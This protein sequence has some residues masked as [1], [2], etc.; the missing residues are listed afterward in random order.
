MIQRVTIPATAKGRRAWL[1]LSI[2]IPALA[3]KVDPPAPSPQ[4]DRPLPAGAPVAASPYLQVVAP[5]VLR[6]EDAAPPPDLSAHPP[7]GAPPKPSRSPGPDVI[8]APKPAAAA[9]VVA[10]PQL[11]PQNAAVRIVPVPAAASAPA[12]PPPPILGDDASPAVKP[13]DFLPYFQYPGAGPGAPRQQP[14]PM[15]RS[16]ATY[17][18]E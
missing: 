2:L 13:E 1:F 12:A 16:T 14:A 5:P 6:F 9:A 4:G 10:A 15:P 18:Q 11:A 3:S 8:L 17:N 7:A